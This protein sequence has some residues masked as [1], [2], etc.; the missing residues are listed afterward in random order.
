VA[1]VKQNARKEE[2]QNEHGLPNVE[3]IGGNTQGLEHG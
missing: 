2:K 1:A 3:D